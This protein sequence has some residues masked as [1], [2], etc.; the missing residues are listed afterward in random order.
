[1]TG[2][3]HL[4]QLQLRPAGLARFGSRRL[5][6]KDFKLRGTVDH[7]YLVHSLL[8]EAFGPG[9]I[10]PF[11]ALV[12]GRHAERPEVLGYAKKSGA[13]LLEALELAA[14][15]I[16]AAIDVESL[17]VKTF[18]TTWTTGRR[19]R[20]ELLA[21]PTVRLASA[22]TVPAATAGQSERHLPAGSEVDA[23][24][25]AAL[26]ARNPKTDITRSEAYLAWLERSLAP[27][28]LLEQAEIRA[29]RRERFGRRDSSRNLKAV[30]GPLV[31]FSGTLAVDA[32]E[33]FA[34]LIA[35]GIGRQR[36]FGLGMLLLR[37]G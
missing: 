15:E 37:P 35:R 30:E 25:H 3:I 8:G 33:E 4:V 10:K 9:T 20:F 27:G 1:M 24:I 5:S 17:A 13:E 34:K 11:R 6:T 21:T 26:V 16:E 23:W 12:E 28:A 22:R 29:F 14:P 2:A 7:G 18:P 31:L 32:P 19:L 36:A